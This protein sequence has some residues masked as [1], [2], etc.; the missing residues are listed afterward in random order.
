MR[1]LVAC[2]FSGAV[3]D[4]FRR[5]GHEAWSCDLE[6]IEP[7]GEWPNYH[8]FGDARWFFEG[9]YGDWDLIIAH[10]PCTY[11][12]NSGAKHLYHGMRKSG[13]I[14]PD[15][16]RSM[17][18]AAAFYTDMIEAPAAHICVENP[19]MLGY[20]RSF[21]DSFKTRATERHIVHPWQFGHGEQKSTVLE[22][23]NLP[24]LKPTDIVEGREQKIWRMGPSPTRQ[25][26]R[27]RTFAGIADAMA[28]QWGSL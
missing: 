22:L 1:V 26:D 19:I 15:R 23:F 4:A 8:L 17:Y 28:D 20:A 11:L 14:D 6:G 27:S 16:Q 13:G 2:E 9:P 3:R 10:P 24:P 18:Q 12:A 21:I 25:R 7:E 5:R